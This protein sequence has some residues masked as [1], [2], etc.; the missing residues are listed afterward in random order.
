MYLINHS[1]Y[2]IFLV[3]DLHFS[4]FWRNLIGVSI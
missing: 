3:N 2:F 1:E 4:G